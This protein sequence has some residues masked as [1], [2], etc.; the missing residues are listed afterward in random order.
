LAI[1]IFEIV[2]GL[3]IGDFIEI[4]EVMNNFGRLFEKNLAINK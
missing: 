3:D 1:N 2:L 4:P